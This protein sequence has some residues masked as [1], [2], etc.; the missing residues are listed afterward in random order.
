M[1][2]DAKFKPAYGKGWN[3]FQSWWT[4]Y[5]ELTQHVAPNLYPLHLL[6]VV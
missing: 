5:V 3:D 1:T 4:G 6:M 2:N